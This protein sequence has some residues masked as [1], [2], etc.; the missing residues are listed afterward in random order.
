MGAVN[1]T[2][3]LSVQDGIAIGTRTSNLPSAVIVRRRIVDLFLLVTIAALALMARLAPLSRPGIN[4]A[5]EPDSYGYIQL[6]EGLTT[7]CGFARRLGG[8][9]QPPEL[10]RTPGYPLFLAVMPSLRMAL[11]VQ[12]MFAGCICFLVASF[13]WLRWGFIAAFITALLISFDVPSISASASV[14]SETLFTSMVSLAVLLQLTIIGRTA[15]DWPMFRAQLGVSVLI[16]VAILVRPI[17]EI[18]LVA[19]SLATILFYRISLVKRLALTLILLCI[20]I[21]LIVGWSY[22]NYYTRGVRIYSSIA[23]VNLYY[24]RAAAVLAYERGQA[25][26]D[27]KSKLLSS[28]GGWDADPR[29]LN[30]RGCHIVLDHPWVMAFIS[31]KFLLHNCFGADW[32]HPGVWLLDPAQTQAAASRS[33][34]TLLAGS[35]RWLSVLGQFILTAVTWIGVLFA[36]GGPRRWRD[37]EVALILIPVSVALGLLLA[38]AGPEGYCRFRVPAVPMLAMVAGCGWTAAIKRRNR[39]AYVD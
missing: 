9:C 10:E 6:A 24:Y 14:M 23:S 33:A 18:V 11:V 12:A 28:T 17:G 19:E 8:K 30:E 7:D 16:A 5:M 31:F 25:F 13:C 39:S 37:P 29:V 4:W 27:V 34:G 22:R 15:V 21:V 36:L 1:R 2:G 32:S 20:P 35:L 38:A 26:E 3:G